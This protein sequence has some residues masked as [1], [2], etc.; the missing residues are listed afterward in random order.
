LQEKDPSK[1]RICNGSEKFLSR[2]HFTDVEE[3]EMARHERICIFCFDPFFAKSRKA[4]YCCSAHRVMYFR[5]RKLREK[6]R[7]RRVHWDRLARKQLELKLGRLQSV[8]E[9]TN[10]EIDEVQRQMSCLICE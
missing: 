9:E 3:Q 10:L 5:R 4:R 2:Y 1:R 7:I 8:L 6:Q